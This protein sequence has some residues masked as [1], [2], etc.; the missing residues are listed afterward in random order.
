MHVY[1]HMHIDTDIITILIIGTYMYVR[2]SSR[3][4]IIASYTITIAAA[5]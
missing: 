4:I 3:H 2:T 1:H 5:A